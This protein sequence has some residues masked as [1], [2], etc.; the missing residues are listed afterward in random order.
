MRFPKD[1]VPSI[2]VVKF[3]EVPIDF[4]LEGIILL[5]DV[6]AAVTSANALFDAVAFPA[7]AVDEDRK[8]AWLM[9]GTCFEEVDVLE[10]RSGAFE[11]EERVDAV[12]SVA[13]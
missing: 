8:A 1:P 6:V 2:D 11:L 9:L 10:V 7:R 12:E 4:A 5:K 3:F 13:D